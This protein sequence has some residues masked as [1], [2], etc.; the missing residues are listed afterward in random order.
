[1]VQ[2]VAALNDQYPKEWQGNCEIENLVDCGG[3]I[4]WAPFM[5]FELGEYVIKVGV[6]D[7]Y[8]DLYREVGP[9]C[10]C[11]LYTRILKDQ[12]L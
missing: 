1:M 4:L 11:A 2:P 8:S 3:V 10:H 12:E 9:G 5:G 7:E 6:D